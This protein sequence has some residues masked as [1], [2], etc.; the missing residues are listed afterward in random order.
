MQSNFSI[1]TGSKSGWAPEIQL[2]QVV[3]A[4]HPSQIQP[5]FQSSQTPVVFVHPSNQMQYQLLT[6]HA[7]YDHQHVGTAQK[8]IAYETCE[9]QQKL[10]GNCN[11]QPWQQEN[12]RRHQQ[13]QL[14]QSQYQAVLI[15]IQTLTLQHSELGKKLR[16]NNLRFQELNY[17]YMISLQSVQKKFDILS[18]IHAGISHQLNTEQGKCNALSVELEE[19]TKN[20]QNERQKYIALSAINSETK[21]S[22]H[23]ERLKYQKLV[24]V[25]CSE[26][27]SSYKGD[28]VRESLSGERPKKMVLN[29]HAKMQHVANGFLGNPSSTINPIKNNRSNA[30]HKMRNEPIIPPG[31][32]SCTRT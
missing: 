8:T 1:P 30:Y 2:R 31:F 3:Q 7:G 23:S 12:M 21:K 27:K 10:L 32:E 29:E 20:L 17:K 15:Q 6:N 14:L 26:G 18:Q 16:L 19:S 22:L 5:V 24:N 4:T 25:S 28:Y 9:S 13:Y 11:I